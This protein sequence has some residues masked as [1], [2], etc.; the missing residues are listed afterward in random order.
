MDRRTIIITGSGR[1][2][3][4]NIHEFLK[5]FSDYSVHHELNFNEMLKAGVLSHEGVINDNYSTALIDSY[6]R[7]MHQLNS[8]GVDVSNAAIWCINE[9][10]SHCK[11]VELHMV[12]RNGYKVVSSFY[13]KFQELMYP[14]NKII[15]ALSAFRNKKFDHMLDKTFWRPLP[16]NIEFYEKYEKQIRFAIICWYWT[17]TVKRFEENIGLF[18]G[19]YRFEDIVSGAELERFSKDLGLEYLATEMLKFFTRPTNIEN[20]VNHKLSSEQ[21]RIFMEI[22]GDYMDKYYSDLDYYDV[23]Y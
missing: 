20:R 18:S 10:H 1:S 12:V 4:H 23:K 3:T 21:Q 15:L 2:G 16:K 14:E 6:L 9:L 8:T 5:N 22:C 17:E 19:F 13:Y 11:D 7:D